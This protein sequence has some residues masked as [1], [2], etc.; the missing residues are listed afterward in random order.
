MNP[1]LAVIALE[2]GGV[3]TAAQAAAAGLDRQTRRDMVR[4]GT[5]RQLRRDV[6]TPGEYWDGCSERERH[7][8]EVA[9]ALIAR[10]WRPGLEQAPILA[11][12][13]MSAGFLHGLP[14]PHDDRADERASWDTEELRFWERRP[15]HVDLISADR[16]R[17]S[18]KYGVEV[19]PAAL[20]P[21]HV[22]LHGVVPISGLAR[23]AVDL[24]REATRPE[25]LMVA[26][27]TMRLGV[28]RADLEAMVEFCGNWPNAGRAREV[29]MLADP[30]A[31]SPAESIARLALIDEHI[32]FEL[33][34]DLF[35]GAGRIGRV[36][37]LLRAF[38]IVLEVDGHVKMLDPWHGTPQ[39]AL[40]RQE[41]REQRLRAVGW[42]VIRTT[43]EEVRHYPE[44]LIERIRSAARVPAPN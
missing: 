7:R 27:A 40:E 24:M 16:G 18:Y 5:L 29:V 11:A 42:I 21:E 9:A 3:F 39:Q 10:G 20:P 2:Q 31:E 32:D 33:Q 35:D 38:G 41:Q 19:R 15:T 37:L 28:S 43:W 36:D 14:L 23:T 44:A 26:D 34:V 30:R 1:T 13:R 8:I 12:G 4:V 17:R 22:D 6:F 25:A